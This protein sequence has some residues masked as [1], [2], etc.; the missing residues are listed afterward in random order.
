MTPVQISFSNHEND[1][2]WSPSRDPFQSVDDAIDSGHIV[3]RRGTQSVDHEVHPDDDPLD[4][5][6]SPSNSDTEID[7]ASSNNTEAIDPFVALVRITGTPLQSVS[8]PEF[9]RCFNAAMNQ[10]CPETYEE[11]MAGEEREFWKRAMERGNAI[12]FSSENLGCQAPTRKAFKTA[13]QES[14]GVC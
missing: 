5:D 10:G 14:L 6:F 9:Y 11:A 8:D 13:W 2:L 3:T 7:S 1:E 12:Y 4:S